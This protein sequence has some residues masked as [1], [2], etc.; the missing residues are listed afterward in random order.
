MHTFFVVIINGLFSK[1]ISFCAN[2][3]PFLPAL[4]THTPHAEMRFIF[5]IAHAPSHLKH[6]H[7]VIEYLG[8]LDQLK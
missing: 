6:I 7:I 4:E 2:V 5:F 1:A 3:P 8:Q